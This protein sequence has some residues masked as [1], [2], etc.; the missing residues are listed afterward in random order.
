[1][2]RAIEYFD[3]EQGD[4]TITLFGDPVAFTLTDEHADKLKRYFSALTMRIDVLQRLT[5]E[6]EK[7]INEVHALLTSTGRST[8]VASAVELIEVT[9]KKK[10][11]QEYEDGMRQDEDE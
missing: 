9:R 1:M 4:Y 10:Y 2:S 3:N 11:D 6:Q 7:T 5:K 8:N